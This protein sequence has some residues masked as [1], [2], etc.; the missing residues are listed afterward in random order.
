MKREDT[1]SRIN[2]TLDTAI[3]ARFKE[4]CGKNTMP[5]GRSLDQAMEVWIRVKRRERELL[6][7][8]DDAEDRTELRSNQNK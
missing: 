7:S 8:L 2:L 5:I 3:Y 6:E 4:E 1:R